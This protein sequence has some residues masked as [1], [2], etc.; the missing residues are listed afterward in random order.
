[1]APLFGGSSDGGESSMSP[2]S[3]RLGS[4]VNELRSFAMTAG[5]MRVTAVPSESIWRSDLR[6]FLGS[7]GVITVSSSK[8]V[9]GSTPRDV[10][11]SLSGLV[12]AFFRSSD[13]RSASRSI[14]CVDSSSLIGSLESYRVS[15]D[16]AGFQQMAELGGRI[17][18]VNVRVRLVFGPGGH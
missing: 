7:G 10:S 1:M 9:D 13:S 17:P 11:R 6:R 2:G 15:P 16:L 4:V 18:D 12:A 8:L 5:S 14:C 3:T